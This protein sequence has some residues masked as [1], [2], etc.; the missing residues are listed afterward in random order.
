M[1]LLMTSVGLSDQMVDTLASEAIMKY[2]LPQ[3]RAIAIA[4]CNDGKEVGSGA[5]AMPAATIRQHQT[6]FERLWNYTHYPHRNRTGEHAIRVTIE[7]VSFWDDY[8]DFAR[9]VD[10]CDLFFMAGFTNQV[11]HVEH[12]F[13]DPGMEEKRSLVANLC[14]T[15]KIAC[16][17]VCGSAVS[18]G[19]SWTLESRKPSMV[20]AQ[21]FGMLGPH[22]TVVYSDDPA[23]LTD[24]NTWHI[25]SGTSACVVLTPDACV[26]SAFRT[27]GKTN[28]K[29]M[30]YY[31]LAEKINE[32][33]QDK[34]R[35]LAV[36]TSVYH[37]QDGARQFQWQLCWGTGAWQ[38]VEGLVERKAG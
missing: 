1:K 21:L 18:L 5:S 4:W 36:A 34:I 6:S 17:G 10:T 13:C 38:L 2:F 11:R 35:H 28:S 37:W 7:Q 9:K 31:Y 8:E 26:A 32:T 24:V 30:F 14:V 20:N 22:G 25:T 3:K 23:D 12:I 33:M 27:V 19:C 15:N 16:W 29:K